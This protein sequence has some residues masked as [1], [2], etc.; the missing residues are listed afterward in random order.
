M[1][2]DSATILVYLFLKK[3]K[4]VCKKEQR[5]FLVREKTDFKLKII[6]LHLRRGRD[7]SRLGLRFP[8]SL[9]F[10]RRLFKKELLLLPPFIR[11]SIAKLIFRFVP[12]SKK[13]DRGD[14]H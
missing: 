5:L 8:K 14:D 2:V 12:H 1:Y 7:K 3:D 9:T 11:G 4:E 10:G 6:L 13:L